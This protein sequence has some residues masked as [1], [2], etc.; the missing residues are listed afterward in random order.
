MFVLFFEG[1]S[2]SFENTLLKK[3][4]ILRKKLFFSVFSVLVFVSFLAVFSVFVS[5]PSAVFLVKMLSE[6]SS[7]PSGTA[8][9]VFVSDCFSVFFSTTGSF[10]FSVTG[11]VCFSLFSVFSV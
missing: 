7:E 3:S 2:E 6:L 10:F 11:S 5:E 1:L 4:I 9:F 8:V